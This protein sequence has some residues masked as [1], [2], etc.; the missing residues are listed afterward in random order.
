MGVSKY[1]LKSLLFREVLTGSCLMG[2]SM[3]ALKCLLVRVKC[4]F[5][6]MY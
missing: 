3:Y 4:V 1:A 5:Q 2:E 6:G